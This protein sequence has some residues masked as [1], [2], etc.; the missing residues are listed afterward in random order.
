MGLPYILIACGRTDVIRCVNSSYSLLIGNL[1]THLPL[2]VVFLGDKFSFFFF[3]FF[4]FFSAF[5]SSR[6]LLLKRHVLK[7]VTVGASRI[8]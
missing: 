7:D 6:V 5:G 1:I 4:F 3:F 2:N 8:L